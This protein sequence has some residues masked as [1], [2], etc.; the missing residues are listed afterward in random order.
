MTAD[1]FGQ[2]DPGR[3]LRLRIERIYGSVPRPGEKR[4][5]VDRLWPRG[6]SKAKAAL[7]E[8]DK[9]IAP[10]TELRKWF[11]HDPAKWD[12]FRTRYLTEL[13]QNPEAGDF[14]GRVADMLAH[15]PVVLLYGAKDEEHNNAVVLRDWLVADDHTK[16]N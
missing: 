1:D 2:D 8:W 13:D 15:G 6:T 11:G 10:G 5:L 9:Q 3:F 14:A 16:K 7:D 12:E 4:I